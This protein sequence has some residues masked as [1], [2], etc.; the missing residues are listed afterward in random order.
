MNLI[1]GILLTLWLAGWAI[2]SLRAMRLARATA[3]A[4]PISRK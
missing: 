1:S 4:G 2:A 3:I